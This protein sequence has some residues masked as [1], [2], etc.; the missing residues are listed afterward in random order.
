MNYL[1][2][3][4]KHQRN[5]IEVALPLKEYGLFFEPGTGKSLTAIN[6][7]RGKCNEHK[8]LLRTL[9]LCP[10]IVIPNW[11]DEWL[12]NSKIEKKDIVLLT[13]TGANRVALL[14]KHCHKIG[15]DMEGD[16]TRIPQG[17]VVV[18]NYETLNIKGIMPLLLEWGVEV[19]VADE[20]HSLK[21]MKSVRT[22]HTLRIA[23]QT[24]Y[25]YI[26]SGTPVLNSPL[27]LFA[28]FLVLDKGAT[29]GKNFFAFRG[30]FFFDKNAGM[31]KQRYFPN[32]QILPGAT[33]AI[34]E[35]ISRKS[36]R[37]EKK[38]CLDLPPYVTKTIK[39]PMTEKQAELY[40]SM[41]EDFIAVFNDK[42]V[43]ATLAITKGLRLMQIA[44]GYVKDI[45][46]EEHQIE[47]ETPKE[48][49]LKELLRELTPHHKVLVW[50]VWKKNYESIRKVC[51]ELEIEFVEVHGDV[52][53][54]HKHENVVRFNSDPSCRVFLGHPGSGGIGI[55][56]VSASYSIFYSRNFSL[57]HSLQAEARNYR[58]GSHIH[59]K[60]TRIDL[61][62]ENT[63]EETVAEKLAKKEEIS[64]SLLRD[65]SL[66]I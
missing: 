9:I 5:A 47:E 10:P 39:V 21:N 42:A 15:T 51:Q 13:G 27:D 7:I 28:Q 54:K 2:E 64:Y 60:V 18:A 58:G 56:L 19:L 40:K 26:L 16:P 14:S 35:M 24:K 23:E 25:R 66:L 41:K 57:E 3:P 11:R 37:V 1:I 34:N 55:N 32:W 49:A 38:N 36:M 62:V 30:R 65:L 46:G 12:K 17:K 63:I 20:C 53:E 59:D 31:P 6:I 22:K 50:A 33:E 52:S 48:A 61:V 43:T 29:F 45:D 44:S 8:R 4:W